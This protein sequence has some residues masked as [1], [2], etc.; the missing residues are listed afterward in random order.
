MK[1]QHCESNPVEVVR[2]VWFLQSYLVFA[3]YGTR[4]Y[5]GCRPCVN[6]QI[7]RSLLVSSLA[8]WWSIPWGL[9]TPAVIAQNLLAL[10]ARSED[11]EAH[12]LSSA[13]LGMSHGTTS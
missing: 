10:V 3:R 8:G 6:R 4:F 9:G 1:C 7:R 12:R 13:G 2:K 11:D 5:V